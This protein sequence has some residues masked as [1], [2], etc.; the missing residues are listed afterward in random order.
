MKLGVYAH[1]WDLRELR[2]SHGGIQALAD[3]GFGSISLA[4]AYHAGKWLTPWSP[5][6]FVRQL[7]DGTVHFPP[8]GDYAA[9]RPLPSREAQTADVEWLRVGEDAAA[10][11]V[12]VRAW[13][14][15]LH[16]TRLGEAHPESTVENARGDRFPWALCPARPEVAAYA[17]T[18][19]ADVGQLPGLGV[20]EVEA[21]GWMGNRHGSHHAKAAIV[22]DPLTDFALSYCFCSACRR[23]LEGRG[24]DAEAL[25]AD[26]RALLHQRLT[27]ADAMSPSGPSDSGTATETLREALG[28]KVVSAMLAHRLEVLLERLADVRRAVPAS[29]VI[30]AHVQPDPLFTGSQLGA[31][32]S[33]LGGAVDEMVA[34]H[35]GQ[36]VDKV[37]AAWQPGPPWPDGMGRSVAILPAAPHYREDAD[38]DRL[39]RELHAAGVDALRVYHLGL[40]PWATTRRVAARL[41]RDD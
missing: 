35:Y 23:G 24:L 27:Q 38:L 30:A 7:E 9:L 1:P 36:S 21:L 2:R 20:L 4:S 39:R 33:S 11:G 13:T 19:A 6:G 10:A 40:L 3:L 17:Q 15:F 14:V 22:D 8:R 31:M 37:I 34:T 18:L 12:G 32:P 26:V 41:R 25:R 5:D 28:E 16:N 29:V